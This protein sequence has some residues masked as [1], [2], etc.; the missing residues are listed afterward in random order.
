M[1]ALYAPVYEHLDAIQAELNALQAHVNDTRAMIDR[2]ER[3][4]EE[5]LVDIVELSRKTNVPVS[6]YRS[7]VGERTIPHY[8]I[9]AD[10]RFNVREVLEAARR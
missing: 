2:I 5:E 3:A 6:T 1:T 10:L 4:E 7:R 9:G 8:K